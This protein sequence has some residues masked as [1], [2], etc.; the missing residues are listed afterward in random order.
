MFTSQ[1]K[2]KP[3]GG[4]TLLLNEVRGISDQRPMKNEAQTRDWLWRVFDD[5]RRQD[6][7]RVSDETV[8]NFLDAV[9]VPLVRL[10][11]ASSTAIIKKH[12]LLGFYVYMVC[13][14]I[15][16]SNIDFTIR[17]PFNF[18]SSGRAVNASPPF[19]RKLK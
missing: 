14:E 15:E 1:Q 19:A 16:G 8:D 12:F 6:Q 9:N 11:H 13:R 18:K 2:A 7:L 5:A 10:R 17:N 4:L 3:P